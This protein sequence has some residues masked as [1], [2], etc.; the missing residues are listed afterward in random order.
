MFIVRKEYGIGGGKVAPGYELLSDH[1]ERAQLTPYQVKEL[2][3][4]I[5]GRIDQI[6]KDITGE[7]SFET[8]E[9]IAARWKAEETP[10]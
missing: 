2:Y 1:N 4:W 3:L 9:E 5:A 6:D 7:F 8:F 10:E